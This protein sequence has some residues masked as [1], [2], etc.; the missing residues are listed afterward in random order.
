MSKLSE[1]LGHRASMDVLPESVTVDPEPQEVHPLEKRTAKKVRPK[2]SSKK[3]QQRDRPQTPGVSRQAHEKM[4]VLT[5]RLP[6]DV[7]E[8]IKAWR[9]VGVETGESET[10]AAMVGRA[11]VDGLKM[12]E[13]A[14]LRELANSTG[15]EIGKPIAVKVPV[16]VHRALK[17]RA[18]QMTDNQQRVTV[19][20]LVSIFVRKRLG[21]ASESGEHR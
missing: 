10:M 3:P 5:V 1:M 12:R 19:Q 15:V 8:M 21:I 6:V 7:H 14:L 11:C 17:A 16:E 18:I 2:T 4:D 20:A 13:N 9:L